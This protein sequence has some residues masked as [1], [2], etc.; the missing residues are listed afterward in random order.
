MAIHLEKTFCVFD[1]CATEPVSAVQRDFLR[2]LNRSPPCANTFSYVNSY[3]KVAIFE[4]ASGLPHDTNIL[5][6]CSSFVLFLYAVH[7]LNKWVVETAQSI[8]VQPYSDVLYGK[9]SVRLNET[10]TSILTSALKMEAARFSETL[11][12]T[13]QSTL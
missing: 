5:I 13:N 6:H 8:C 4:D 11:T 3:D 12:S 2:K 7:F 1:F 9:I 10:W